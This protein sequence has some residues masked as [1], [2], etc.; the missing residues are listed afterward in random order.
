MV[1]NQV[2]KKSMRPASKLRRCFYCKEDVGQQHKE[3]CVCI[4]KKA[5]VKLTIEYD[6]EIPEHWNK[7]IL[8]YF[9]NDGTWCANNLIDELAELTEGD[10]C[11]CL[12][13]KYEYLRH[14]SEPYLNEV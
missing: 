3:D 13:A 8:E 7:E 2:T 10:N 4:V 9:R 12:L 6:I 11:L 14:V 1:V 5:R